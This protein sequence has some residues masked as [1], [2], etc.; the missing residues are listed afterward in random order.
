M[1]S[2][3][4]YL[5]RYLLCLVC[6]VYT[7]I[8]TAQAL[9]RWQKWLWADE[10]SRHLIRRYLFVHFLRIRLRR[11]GLDV[12]QIIVLAAILWQVIRLHGHI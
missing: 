9:W 7:A 10:R 5:F 11:F 12:L 1:N 3:L 8:R 2:D 4:F 6:T